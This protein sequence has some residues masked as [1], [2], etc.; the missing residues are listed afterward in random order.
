M[1]LGSS[2]ATAL[3]AAGILLWWLRTPLPTTIEPRKPQKNQAATVEP[4]IAPDE[5]CNRLITEFVRSQPDPT[6]ASG[7]AS[8][9]GFRGRTLHN[10]VPDGPPLASHWPQAGPP[11]RWEI[12]VG[13]GHAG[14]AVFAGCVYLMDYD[15]KNRRDTLRCLSLKDGSEI[16]RRSYPVVIKRNHGVSR[17]VPAVTKDFIVTMG[18]KCQVMCVERASGDFLWGL[19]LV[20]DY[21]STVPLWYTAQ[22]P[23]IDAGVAV[24]APAGRDLL[25]G[26]DCRS[27]DILWRTPNPDGWSMSHSSIVMMTFGKTRAY[28]YA[29]LGGIV[30]VYAEGE[31]RGEVLWKTNVWNHKVVAP[32]P[33]QVGPDRLFMT[34]GHGAGSMLLRLGRVKTTWE[35]L[36]NTVIDKT[37]FASEQQTPLYIDGLLYGILPK[38]AGAHREELAC[39]D[40]SGEQ[41]RLWTSGMEMRFGLGPT[42]MV[43]G[44]LFVL[45]DEGTLSMLTIGRRGVKLLAR[46]DVLPHGRD[47]WGPPAYVDGLLLLR[48]S[49]RLICLDLRQTN[50]ERK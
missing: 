4:E 33:A 5:H 7:T 13:D 28:V 27:G 43:D 38:D 23:L 40:P 20:R 41:K 32:C 22:C 50:P 21:G 44:K 47:A 11:K 17:T 18:P 26:L 36:E 12:T 16:W 30:A 14:P 24:L 37:M 10:V 25:M 8:W 3:L 34:S 6:P 29:A 48:D 42:L 31:H 1:T 9:P 49:T 46:A 45:D 2:A 35:V 39:F 15:E 19:D